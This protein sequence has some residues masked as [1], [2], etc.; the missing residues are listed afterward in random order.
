M[1]YL[2]S[3]YS[4]KL[5]QWRCFLEVFI[6]EH[7]ILLFAINADTSQ[8]FSLFPS[9]V[10]TEIIQYFGDWRRHFDSRQRLPGLSPAAVQ[11]SL[12]VILRLAPA[13]WVSPKIQANGKPWGRLALPPLKSWCAF[14][15]SDI[16]FTTENCCD[17]LQP[18][19]GWSPS[20]LHDTVKRKYEGSLPMLI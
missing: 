13:F 8:M 1:I 3:W 15:T 10:P 7:A 17:R 18:Q 20:C 19:A 11:V 4:F 16:I 12:W 6:T 14:H 9:L 5:A 2:P